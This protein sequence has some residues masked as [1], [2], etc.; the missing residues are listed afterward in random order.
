MRLKAD[1]KLTDLI[2][3]AKLC[4][5]DVYYQTEEGDVLNLKSFLTQYLLQSIAYS[6]ASLLAGGQIVCMNEEEN[7]HF[8]EFV[9]ED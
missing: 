6:D 2:H 4:K 3:R 1:V 7:T 5:E 9:V 8:S